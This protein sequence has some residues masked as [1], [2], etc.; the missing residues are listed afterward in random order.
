LGVKIK[1]NFLFLAPNS[2]TNNTLVTEPTNPFIKSTNF[3][4]SIPI[5]QSEIRHKSEIE[6]EVK[7]E[8]QQ[9]QLKTN[10]SPA[11][12]TSCPPIVRPTGIT[13][14]RIPSIL[15]D[16]KTLPSH[17]QT[18]KRRIL[19][20]SIQTQT[21]SLSS[22]QHDHQIQQ[23]FK[24]LADEALSKNEKIQALLHELTDCQVRVSE[25]CLLSFVFILYIHCRC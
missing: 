8:K 24:S 9:Q 17:Y 11:L 6:I 7:H 5:S 21:P 10:I 4:S 12:T 14:K 16:D 15:F 23:Q 1:I 13:N 22:N 3:I 20:N 19:T 18:P 2:P 25:V